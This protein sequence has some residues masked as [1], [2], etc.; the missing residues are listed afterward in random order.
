MVICLLGFVRL[1]FLADTSIEEE[2][3]LLIQ[4]SVFPLREDC[5]FRF[6]ANR[7]TQWQA[8]SLFAH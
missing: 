3:Y 4:G 2:F 1:L 6:Q 8:D 7:Y 5:Q